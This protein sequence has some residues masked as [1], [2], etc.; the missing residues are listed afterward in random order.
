[1]Q[2]DSSIAVLQAL[3]YVV[4]AVIAIGFVV[5]QYQLFTI[6]DTLK[7]ILQE[8]RNNRK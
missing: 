2:E 5:A 6:S 4:A 1:M 8:L 3:A 7:A